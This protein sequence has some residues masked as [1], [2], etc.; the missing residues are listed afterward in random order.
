MLLIDR[1]KNISF[2]FCSAT[3]PHW[4]YSRTREAGGR[5]YI[6]CFH[7]NIFASVQ[8]GRSSLIVG[9]SC[10]AWR[11]NTIIFLAV[12][13]CEVRNDAVLLDPSPPVH[14]GRLSIQ[15]TR[16]SLKVCLKQVINIL[17]KRASSHKVGPF[18]ACLYKFSIYF[19]A[20]PNVFIC[21][22]SY[23]N[24]TVS[25]IYCITILWVTPLCVCIFR[26]CIYEHNT[27][28]R[29]YQQKCVNSLKNDAVHISDFNVPLAFF[30]FFSFL[31]KSILI[32]KIHNEHTCHTEGISS[33]KS[34]CVLQPRSQAAAMVSVF[35]LHTSLIPTH[36]RVLPLLA[37]TP[38][39]PLIP[40]P[41]PSTWRTTVP[42]LPVTHQT[43]LTPAQDS[44]KS[45]LFF[46]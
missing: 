46:T 22:S 27:A 35:T 7:C 1:Y 15:S 42:A 23:I 16:K 11:Q 38:V 26:L 45:R 33:R 39:R 36:T 30:L 21:I 40:H 6:M 2:A 20:S 24:K 37:I 17:N 25:S 13:P 10:L 44:N 12:A 43:P 5:C 29:S 18:G 28:V 41:P 14:T 34:I 31:S 32:K 4:P 8:T 19:C 9:L 3:W